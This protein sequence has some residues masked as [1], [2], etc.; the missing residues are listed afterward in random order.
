MLQGQVVQH[1]DTIRQLNIERDTVQHE[2]E[3][4]LSE[5]KSEHEK[6]R[7]DLVED[8]SRA[9][10]KLQDQISQKEADNGLLQD[11]IN[12]SSGVINGLNATNSALVSENEALTRRC[13]SMQT[14]L[15]TKEASVRTN[16]DRVKSKDQ[17]IKTLA[18]IVKNHQGE[19]ER[20][21]RSLDTAEQHEQWARSKAEAMRKQL[22]SLKAFGGNLEDSD[23]EAL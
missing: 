4:E 13:E 7:L 16:E 17:E 2:H 19:I 8:H 6:R 21:Q 5:Q 22:L 10:R 11:K 3:R 1:T 20:M 18:G 23:L 12:V 14:A 15:E 9:H